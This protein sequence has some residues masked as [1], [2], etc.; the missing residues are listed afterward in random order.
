M[1]G[2]IRLAEADAKVTSTEDLRVRLVPFAVHASVNGHAQSAVFI[3]NPA[4][5]GSARATS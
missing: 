2:W 1:S 5:C 4:R 3:V